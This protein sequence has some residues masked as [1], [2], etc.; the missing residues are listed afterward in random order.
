MKAITMD[1][2]QVSKHLN[3]TTIVMETTYRNGTIQTKPPGDQ[4]QQEYRETRTTKI[5]DTYTKVQLRLTS[6]QAESARYPAQRRPER[7]IGNA[8]SGHA[9]PS[10]GRGTA[11]QSTSEQRLLQ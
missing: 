4:Q 5:T 10:E 6:Q 3:H 9:R 2:Q 1:M 8:D 7:S 11:G